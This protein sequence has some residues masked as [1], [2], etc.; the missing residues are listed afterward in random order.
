MY[1]CLII[2]NFFI[3]TLLFTL[4]FYANA[5]KNTS[6]NTFLRSFNFKLYFTE[7][8]EKL[9]NDII[10]QAES[11]LEAMENFLGTRM[12]EQVDIFL[13]EQPFERNTAELQRNGR[14]NLD[15]SSIYL[16]YS[17]S[18]A[19][20]ILQLKKQLA[21][22]LINGMLYGNTVKERLKNN[23]EINVP[24][25]YVSGLARYV[26]GGNLPDISWMSDYYED[27]LK[28]NL[29][30]TSPEE[31]AEFGH[32]IFLHI[33]DSFG[34]SKLRQL[35]FY[36]KLS[37]K[38]EFAFEY[39]FNKSL[40][41]MLSDWYKL[42]KKIYLTDNLTRLPSDPENIGKILRYST[43]LDLK[44]NETATNIDF[45]IKTEFGIQLWNYEL[46]S[47]KSKKVFT[48]NT[49]NLNNHWTFLATNS[50]YILA[51]S[52]GAVSKVFY[53]SKGKIVKKTELD[54]AYIKSFKMHPVSGI[55]F[56]GQKQYQTDVFQL[57]PSKNNGLINLTR[58][59]Q[60]E[61]D[62]VVIND[63]SLYYT[64][65]INRQYGVYR[66]G[67]PLPIYQTKQPLFKLNTYIAPYL[68]LV[69][70]NA[71]GN[72]GLLI[73]PMDTM[74]KFRVTNY[75]RSILFYDYNSKTKQV[76]EGIKY[77]NVNYL[78]VSEASIDKAK[79][80]FIE[81]EITPDEIQNLDTG[82][83]DS[84]IT[85][86]KFI[87]G[88]EYKTVKEAVRKMDRNEVT[89][90]NIKVRTYAAPLYEFKSDFIRLGY[91]NSTFN[92]PLFAAFYPI[93]QGLYN[94]PNII[95]GAGIYDI[96]KR[97]YLKG[98]IRQPITGKGTDFDFTLQTF[99]KEKYYSVSFFNSNFQ[100]EI[101]NQ[102]NRFSI[103][104]VSVNS[105]QKLNSRVNALFSVGYRTDKLIPLSESEAN[106]RREIL[107]LNQPFIKV[108]FI[109]QIVSKVKINYRHKM[110]VSSQINSFKPID[111]SGF[112]TNVFLKL[113]YMQWFYRIL[114]LT[115]EIHAQSSVGNQKTVFL[116][117]GSSNWL[118]PVYANSAIY[119]PEK[120]M[121]YSATEDFEG[122]PYN[123][124]AGTSM[125]MIKV[126]L[127]F[128][129]NPL[130]SQQNFNQ[131][132]FKFLTVRSY[133]NIG[134]TWFGR[135][136]FAI[137]NPDNQDIYETGSM[138][139]V[140]YS[141]KNPLIWSWGAGI[142]SIL[143]GYEFGLDFA[144]GYNERGRIGK[145]TY[146]TVGKTF[147]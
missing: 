51:Q 86:Y 142:N 57:L 104:Q 42:S 30:L 124:A 36:T 14:I 48:Y 122:L 47:K 129:L 107:S 131:N 114:M 34:V 140:N 96:K 105:D 78:V 49:I 143:F 26:A 137:T 5:K 4:A 54:F 15:N 33:S 80:N 120:I 16:T 136:P 132:V 64:T 40:N 135:N 91:T 141:A 125:S 119:Y 73:N 18:Q 100:K 17:G 109:S 62:Y 123:Y 144:T 68:S 81:Q 92:S 50:G 35:L 85:N 9:A 41:Q 76:L 1:F 3:V 87:T 32:A 10:T 59:I 97:Y 61:I 79:L 147:N 55:T 77:G 6:S 110:I 112:N 56:L 37:G 121:M 74:E 63:S 44:F 52:N 117:G 60:E 20:V 24:N 39:V 12:V 43:I 29:N 27:K 102:L 66:K 11:N 111:Y 113:K 139:I 138:T 95:V 106:L 28:L 25:W 116:L 22:I 38:T 71:S 145:F 127:A 98:N 69:Q 134:T 53:I 8:G 13:S 7:G 84:N 31:L 130:L 118:R 103:R 58:S 67:I 70:K 126:K 133:T 88:F 90:E 94:G 45:L 115:T 46:E 108:G 72:F 128:P 89:T 82:D 19:E 93:R 101:Y 75:N 146:F 23:R 65:L 83:I 99:Q 21:E 2:R